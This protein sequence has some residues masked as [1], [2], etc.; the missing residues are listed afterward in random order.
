MVYELKEIELKMAH[1]KNKALLKLLFDSE[2]ANEVN[3]DEF[4]NFHLPEDNF[5]LPLDD[6]DVNYTPS[7]KKPMIM[8]DLYPDDF[9]DDDY[10]D[11]DDDDYYDDSSD[12]SI[13][14]DNFDDDDEFIKACDNA[15]PN[16]NDKE[17][18]FSRY[19]DD[20]QQ[21]DPEITLSEDIEPP[22]KIKGFDVRKISFE[23]IRFMEVLDRLRQDAKNGIRPFS[24]YDDSRAI[25]Y[26]DDESSENFGEAICSIVFDH[27]TGKFTIQKYWKDL[28]PG[29][30]FSVYVEDEDS[31]KWTE[32]GISYEDD[33]NCDILCSIGLFNFR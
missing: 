30:R 24:E 23:T 33:P 1:L 6:E 22:K 8:G 18:L 5:H 26:D 11:Y 3:S 19:I 27:N 12:G 9:D 20:S 14:Y 17:P 21:S 16:P 28:Y 10:D 32:L 13:D 7:R 15:I 2:K 25:Y 31:E 4:K 29:L